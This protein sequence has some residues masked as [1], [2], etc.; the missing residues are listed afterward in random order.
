MFVFFQ[1]PLHLACISGDLNT[2]RMLCEQDGVE[3]DLEDNNHKTPCML[4]KGRNHSDIVGY[5]ERMLNRRRSIIPH[6]DFKYVFT[7]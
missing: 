1:T 5:L 7:F 6:I 4:A 2:V 3:I